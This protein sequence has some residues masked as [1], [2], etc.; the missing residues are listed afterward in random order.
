MPIG[1]TARLNHHQKRPISWQGKT[2]SQVTTFVK[3]NEGLSTDV[4][5]TEDI[6]KALPAKHYRK[7][8]ASKSSMNCKAVSSS[9]SIMQDMER[10]GGS[11]VKHTITDSHG[12]NGLVNTLDITYEDTKSARPCSKGCDETLPESG[13]TDSR[14][15][16]SLSQE[17]NARRRV[18]SSGINRPTYDTNN[19]QKYYSSTREYLH[20]R[21]RR[22]S[23]NDFY[24]HMNA[25]TT[26]KNE[27]R[28]NTRSHCDQGDYVPV[29]Y[30]PNNAKFAVQ[31]AVDSSSRLARLKYDTITNNAS[32]YREAFDVYGVGNATANA[33]AYGVPAG[34]Y[35]IKDKIGYPNKRSI[36][37][38]A[39]QYT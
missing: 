1:H 4:I 6:M 38:P 37:V 34:G 33:L 13:R 35:T 21:N 17:E 15:L 16:R 25:S 18:R 10:P 39:R 9:R 26:N 24:Y 7:E 20:S 11:I 5:T 23:Q 27:F 31:G 30:K 19:K 22:H 29:H 32:T 36:A 14:D 28:S 8:I 12:S 2:F 3:Q